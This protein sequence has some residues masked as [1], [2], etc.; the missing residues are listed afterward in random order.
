ME[1]DTAEMCDR[2][3][4]RNFAVSSVPT[5]MSENPLGELISRMNHGDREAAGV[6][7]TRYGPLIRRRIRGK[8]AASIRR[9]AD[10]GDILSTLG[11]RLDLYVRNGRFAC[12]SEAELWSLVQT[13]AQR[14]TVE[15]ARIVS[16]ITRLEREDSPLAQ[17]VRETLQEHERTSEDSLEFAW[18]DLMALLPDPIDRTIAYHWALGCSHEETSLI[19]GLS[20]ACVR[21]RWERAKSALRTRLKMVPS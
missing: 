2:K 16:S 10:T 12:T 11:R 21:K 14:S 13:I 20:A 9:V 4:E 15:K 3:L 17:R 18:D 6:F 5:E 19:V 8:V 1:R 7:L